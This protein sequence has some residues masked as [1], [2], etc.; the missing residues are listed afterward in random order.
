[1]KIRQLQPLRRVAPLQGDLRIAVAASAE[2][3][4]LFVRRRLDD[5]R[6]ALQSVAESA[7]LFRGEPLRV[8]KV[9]HQRSALFRGYLQAVEMLHARDRLR[10]PLRGLPLVVDPVQAAV[11]EQAVARDAPGLQDDLGR[12][13]REERRDSSQQQHRETGHEE[14]HR[15]ESPSPRRSSAAREKN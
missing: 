5:V 14:S 13:G 4:E 8:G 12:I 2:D 6:A 7:R 15:R 3:V 9:L 10:P 1:V 11:F